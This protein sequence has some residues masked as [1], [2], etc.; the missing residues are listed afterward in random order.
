MANIDILVTSAGQ[1]TKPALDQRQQKLVKIA[2]T[3]LSALGQNSKPTVAQWNTLLTS[4]AQFLSPFMKRDLDAVKAAIWYQ[5]AI[6]G[7][8]TGLAVAGKTNSQILDITSALQ[9]L[10]D[11]TLDSLAIYLEGKAISI[12][13]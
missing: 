1:F 9:G 2:Y 4:A 7:I 5:N 11:A 13:T 6:A 8:G 12:L 3:G 10:D